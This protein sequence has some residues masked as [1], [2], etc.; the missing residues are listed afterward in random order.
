M[1]QLSNE[2]HLTQD[3]LLRYVE[4]D[5]SRT[6][7]REIDRHL[8]TCALCCDAVEGLMLLPEPSVTLDNLNKRIDAQVWEKTTE[9]TPEKP[10][11]EPVLTVVKNPFWQQRWAAA[12]AVLLLASSSIWIYKNTQQPEKQAIASSEIQIAPSSELKINDTIPPQYSRATTT[13]SETTPPQYS[14][15]TTVTSKTTPA[16]QPQVLGEKK[17]QYAAVEGDGLDSISRLAYKP[18]GAVA[19][20]TTADKRTSPST[21]TEIQTYYSD[22]ST[23][24]KDGKTPFLPIKTDEFKRLIDSDSTSKNLENTWANTKADKKN[25]FNE[26]Y[27]DKE[28]SGESVVQKASNAA[29]TGRESNAYFGQKTQTGISLNDGIGSNNQATPTDGDGVSDPKA[30]TIATQSY[31]RYR[32]YPGAAAQNIEPRREVMPNGLSSS[33]SPEMPKVPSPTEPTSGKGNDANALKEEVGTLSKV[34]PAEEKQVGFDKN[35]EKVAEVGESKLKQSTRGVT[36]PVKKPATSTPAPPAAIPN[37]PVTATAS[38]TVTTTTSSGTTTPFTVTPN[39]SSATVTSTTSGTETPITVTGGTYSTYGSYPTGKVIAYTPDQILR[40]A[41]SHFKQKKYTN[42]AAQYTQFTN[43][44]TLGKRHERALFQTAT[45]YVKLKRKEEA[46][47]IFE[48]L[49]QNNGSYKQA[50]K[51]ALKGLK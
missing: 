51:R 27:K 20:A 14:R 18:Y 8:T 25:I 12:A 1:S 28:P 49:V 42:A 44:E 47:A 36:I 31:D 2:Q 21:E 39:A 17:A 5:C 43:L 29:V 40:A 34:E 37:V 32:D 23:V 19:G 16:T 41:D 3:Q 24:G 35:S 4:D 30:T 26:D 50:A 11:T 13:K 10:F 33:P 48:Q 38:G 6:E 46:K 45:C 7:M 9:K 15:A 22:I